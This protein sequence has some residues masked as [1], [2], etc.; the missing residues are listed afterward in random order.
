MGLK[1][2]GRTGTG[3][4]MAIAGIGSAVVCTALSSIAIYFLWNM[5]SDRQADNRAFDNA[6]RIGLAFHNS[7]DALGNLFPAYTTRPGLFMGRDP[8]PMIERR[9]SWRTAALPFLEQD[10]LFRQYDPTQTWNSTRNQAVTA[11]HVPAF[12]DGADKTN[13]TRF[14]VFTGPNT[15]FKHGQTAIRLMN[16]TDGTSNTAL[17]AESADLGPWGEPKDMEVSPV[18]PMPALGKPD[19]QFAIILMAD[20]SVRRIRKTIDERTL[21]LLVDPADGQVV[22][23]EW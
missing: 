18:G 2:S 5:K 17:M 7:H 14:R 6:K 20:G 9:T 16:I 10:N 13:Q 4:G 3:Q 11:T 23:L 22:P 8:V 19:G 15:P 21:R 12:S 1:N